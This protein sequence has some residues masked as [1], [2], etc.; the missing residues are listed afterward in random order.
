[1]SAAAWREGIQQPHKESGGL[2]EVYCVGPEDKPD[3]LMQC[4][5]GDAQATGLMRAVVDTVSTIEGARQRSPMLCGC[6][7]NALTGSGFTVCVA[8]PERADP[9]RGLGF[10]LCRECRRD[11]DTRTGKAPVAQGRDWPDI[12]SGTIRPVGGRA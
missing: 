6:C 4:L 12:R 5:T 9:T 2:F 3:L 8:V 1:M 7:P 11:T 10:V